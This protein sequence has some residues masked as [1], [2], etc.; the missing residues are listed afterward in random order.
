MRKCRHIE[1]VHRM[2]YEIHTKTGISSSLGGSGN[3]ST[4]Y[5]V[6]NSFHQA[7]AA[8]TFIRKNGIAGSAAKRSQALKHTLGRSY[9]NS[10]FYKNQLH[11]GF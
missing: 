5:F 8:P 3:Q 6:S 7:D 2:S 10:T 1:F 4:G 11:M 9:K